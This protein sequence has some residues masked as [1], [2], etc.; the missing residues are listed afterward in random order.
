MNE[1][2][3]FARREPRSLLAHVTRD[4]AQSRH[5]SAEDAETF[6]RSVYLRLLEADDEATGQVGGR[7]YRTHLGIVIGRMA[8]EWMDANSSLRG[9]PG[10]LGG[11]FPGQT[12]PEEPARGQEAKHGL[13]HHNPDLESADSVILSLALTVEARDAYTD[14][15]CQRLARYATLVGQEIGLGNEQLAALHRGGCLHDVGKI[16][17]PD[18]I[19]LKPTTLTAGEFEVVKQHPIIGDKLC[20][21][22]RSLALVRPIVRHHHERLN[23]SGY[24]DGLKGDQ[25]PLLAQI[26]GIVDAFDAMTTDRPYRSGRSREY[27]FREIR[28]SAANSLFS[29]DLVEA[30]IRVCPFPPRSAT[31]ATAVLNEEAAQPP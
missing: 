19:L 3:L 8:E 4:V 23:G 7:S 22:L 14:G 6:A 2:L 27:A 1:T 26:V 12:P 28:R 21:E 20:G 30:F 5:L 24:P 16:G 13:E 9:I 29:S 18:A 11:P 17:V 31:C 10:K 25:I 15:H